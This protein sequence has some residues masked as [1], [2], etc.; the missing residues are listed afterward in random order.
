MLD[1]KCR[2]QF[3]IHLVSQDNT[4]HGTL[5]LGILNPGMFSNPDFDIALRLGRRVLD[6]ILETL[7]TTH[8][9]KSA[10]ISPWSVSSQGPGNGLHDDVQRL[11][12][13]ATRTASRF[14]L[15]SFRIYEVYRPTTVLVKRNWF[16]SCFILCFCNISPNCSPLRHL[17][18]LPHGVPKVCC[19]AVAMQEA[20]G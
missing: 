8:I 7:H 13:C 5:I 6:E 15:V 17:T 18:L 1:R 19:R 12:D 3:R 14:P 10:E 16:D 4:W 9:G 20:R 2:H 11:A